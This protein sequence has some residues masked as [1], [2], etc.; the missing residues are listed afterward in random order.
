MTGN[1]DRSIRPNPHDPSV[2]H[3]PAGAETPAAE[4]D[5][6]TTGPTQTA[7]KSL[8]RTRISY[9]WIGLVAGTLVLLLLLVFILQNT[10]QTDYAFLLWSFSLPL[11]V[12]VLLAAISGALIMALVGGIRILQIRRAITRS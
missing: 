1:P 4:S 2:L 7:P 11:G 3:D 10:E 5:S 12:G 6:A 8:G 9:T